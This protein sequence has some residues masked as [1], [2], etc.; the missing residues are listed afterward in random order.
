[1]RQKID[2]F[3]ATT[4]DPTVYYDKLVA[5]EQFQDDTQIP[6]VVLAWVREAAEDDRAF[7]VIDDVTRSRDLIK[8]SREL[9]RKLTAVLQSPA[10]ARAFPELKAGLER[11]LGL[12][13]KVALARRSLAMGLDSVNPSELSGEI[14]R[15][16]S[17]RRSLMKRMGWLPVTDADFEHRESSGQHQWNQVSQKLQGLTIEADKLNAMVN[18]LRK[19]M[20]E[21]DRQG[22]K[23]DPAARER[24]RAELEANER[25]LKMY[26]ERLEAY[27]DSIE[28]GHVQIGFGDQRYVEDDDVRARFREVLAREV[29]LA[30]SGQADSDSTAYARSVDSVL[31]KADAVDAKLGGTRRDLEDKVRA[32]TDEIQKQVDAE[33]ENIRVYTG[34]LDELDQNARVLVGEVAM[35]NFALVRDRLKSIILRADTGIVQQAWEI[36]EEQLN[37]VRTLQR[38][39]AREDQNLSDELREVL[40][41]AGG[42][43]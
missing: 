7:A 32:G 15:V 3:V 39:R 21:A 42:S 23:Q 4:A 37:R 27:R 13:N 11:T 9:I 40:D 14:G 2:T 41:D 8:R 19:L 17:E 29:Q 5:E 34:H 6:R 25:D 22:I 33:A 10:R 36:R 12:M 35:K 1:M 38:E 43:Q 31:A 18:A 28:M 20:D 16:R 30:S 26:H 24:F